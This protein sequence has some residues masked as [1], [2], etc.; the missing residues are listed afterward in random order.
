MIALGMGEDEPWSQPPENTLASLRHAI[1]HFDGI[2]FDIRITADR[3]LIVHHDR[4]V[5][6]PKHLV[7]NKPHWVEEWKHDDL[8]DL[9]FLSFSDLL[10][11]AEVQRAWIEE[12]KMGCI[13]IKR[14]HPKA[15]TGGGYLGRKQHNQHVADAMRLAEDLL[16]EHEV[17]AENTVFYAFHKGMP[18]S[19]M[20]SQT[21]RPWAAL[22]PYIPP[23]GNRNTQRLQALPQYIS[24]PFKRLVNKHRKQ[25]SSM[26]PCAVEYFQSSTRRLP[27]GRPVGLH[28]SAYQRL[29][30]SRKGMP[31]Y[32]WP[33]RPEIEHRLLRSGMTALTDNAD[34]ALTWLPSGHARWR[35]PGTR[36]LTEQQWTLLEQVQE[37][38][39]R[40]LL[41]ELEAESPTWHECDHDRRNQLVR[42]WKAQWNWP[43][44]VEDVLA[45]SSGAT[46]PWPAP[47]MIGHRGSGKTSRP[48]LHPHSM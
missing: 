20:L 39:H 5:S 43:A 9:G 38:D 37:D 40:A 42:E 25:G 16:D 30:R 18:A 22:I 1:T 6:V 34:P 26:L 8:V 19:A 23:Y 11:N 21:K 35:Q 36:P 46:P 2:E 29:N 41:R 33:T 47:R 44:S 28:G 27:F 48:V 17:P 7:A 12:G 14:P 3:Q 24:T 10:G 31:T 45:K 4:D 13:E 15:A 32:V